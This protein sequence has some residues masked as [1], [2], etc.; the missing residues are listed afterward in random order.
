MLQGEKEKLES[1][2][3]QEIEALKKDIASYKQAARPVPPDNSIGRL[4]RM[5]AINS[6]SVSEASLRQA[7][8][9]LLKMERALKVIDDPDF[10]L[11]MECGDPIPFKRLMVLPGSVLCVACAG[12]KR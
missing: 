3:R 11:C 7:K 12:K 1:H 6:K 10:G 8:N 4:T 9:N 2:I 5:E